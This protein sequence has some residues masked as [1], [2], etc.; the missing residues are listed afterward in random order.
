VHRRSRDDPNTNPHPLETPHVRTPTFTLGSAC[1]FTLTSV[2]ATIKA[3]VA[4]AVGI[5]FNMIPAPIVDLVPDHKSGPGAGY[6]ENQQ[7]EVIFPIG[8]FRAA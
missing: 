6:D 1:A 4:K 7:K 2:P 5:L 8:K 3:A